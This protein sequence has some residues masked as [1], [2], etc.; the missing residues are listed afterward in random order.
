MTI[1]Q[2]PEGGEGVSHVKI[3]KN[4]I[5]ESGHSKCKSPL[6]GSVL[7]MFKEQLRERGKLIENEVRKVLGEGRSGH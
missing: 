3:W 1:E 7:G 2:R 6:N 5:L 4:I